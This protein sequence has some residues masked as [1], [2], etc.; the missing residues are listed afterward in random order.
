MTH[1]QLLVVGCAFLV[2]LNENERMN[3]M[4]AFLGSVSCL[5]SENEQR[6]CAKA[7]NLRNV[8]Q[9]AENNLAP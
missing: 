1:N 9:S 2:I 7:K 8:A 3:N 4:I 6:T 5:L